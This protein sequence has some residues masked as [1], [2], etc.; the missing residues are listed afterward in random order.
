MLAGFLVFAPAAYAKKDKH[1][2]Q[3]MIS[4]QSKVVR[5]LVNLFGEIDGL[6]LENGTLVKLPPHMSGDVT[7][8]AK[9]GDTLALQGTPEAGASFKAYS[10]T[11]TASNQTLLRRRPVWGGKVMP[12]HL[13]AVG[14]KELSAGGRIK[15]VITGKRGEPKIILLENGTNVRLPKNAAYGANSLIN[16]GA[17]FVAN[18]YGTETEYGRSLEATAIG[19]SAAS[20]KP[21]FGTLG[22]PRQL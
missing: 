1:V 10:A 11:N 2:Q 14:L 3:P 13:R 15:Q 5:Y 12:K 4:L 22:K 6:F 16:V 19:S 7:A 9:P 17:P 8:L 20:L 21:L 18:G